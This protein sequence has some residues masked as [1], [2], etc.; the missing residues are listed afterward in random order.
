MNAFSGSAGRSA[1]VSSEPVKRCTVDEILDLRWRVLRPGRPLDSA[2]YEQ[3]LLPDTRHWA[4]RDAEG[5]VVGCVT[6]QRAPFPGGDGPAWQ[7]R[8]MAVDEDLQGMGI[9]GDVLVF[10]AREVAEPIWCNAR[11]RAIPF[12]ASHGWKIVSDTF[13]IPDVGPHKRM[14][15]TP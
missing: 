10:A 9:G 4:Y 2:R 7:L 3:D 12:Y 5:R 1:N 11:E 8:G 13:D 6:V 14:V 15:W